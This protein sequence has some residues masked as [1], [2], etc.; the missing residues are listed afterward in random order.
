MRWPWSK[1]ETRQ[2]SYTDALVS[3]IQSR[4]GGTAP[5]D[6][7]AIAALET[8]AGLWARCFAAAKVSP[9]GAASAVSPAVLAL[10]GRE[11]CRRGEAV[12]C[13]KIDGG[14]SGLRLLPAGSWDVR[15]GY[16]ERAWWYR[17][18]LFGP[19]GSETAVL[20]SAGVVHPR[21][22]I[23]P[24]R[25]W[26]GIGPLQWARLTGTL[27]ANLEAR[28]GDE[29]G[30]PVGA[31]LPIPADGGDGGDDDPLASLKDDIRGAR[32]RQLLVE[33]VSAGWGEGRTAAP[34]HDWKPQRFGAAPPESLPVLRSDAALSVLGACGVPPSL[35]MDADGTAARESWRRFVMGTVEPILNGPVRAELA[36]KLGLPGLRFD[37]MGLWAHDGAGRA[38][39]FSKLVAGGLSPLD[40][41]QKSGLLSDE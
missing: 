29:A 34:Q 41:L 13:L 12:L 24:A 16:D 28:L 3:L 25:P 8:A 22:A 15:G 35:A 30:A 21:Y 1:P 40:A 23:D 32:G 4:A 10:L 7:S 38:T 33:T 27:A 5:G 6:P 14:G 18:D 26:V 39:M 9:E 17:C 11:L 36:E 19:S 20:P 31:L 2:T 37:L